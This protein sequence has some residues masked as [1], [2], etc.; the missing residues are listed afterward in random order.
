MAPWA[1]TLRTG[2]AVIDGQHRDLAGLLEAAAGAAERLDAAGTYALLARFHAA[3]R[4]HFLTEQRAMASLVGEGLPGAAAQAHLD[5]HEEFLADVERLLAELGQRG[6]ALL[7][8]LWISSRLAEWLR[9]HTRTMDAALAEALAAARQG[10]SPDRVD[11][12]P[13]HH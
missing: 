7:I 3:C 9:F 11:A 13:A 2:D 12:N 6:P 5:S 4:E 1:Q 10:R 8:R